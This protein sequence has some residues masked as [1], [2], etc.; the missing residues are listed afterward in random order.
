M[1]F[2]FWF[3]DCCFCLFEKKSRFVTNS[4]VVPCNKEA[5]IDGWY[6]FNMD[7]MRY[8][9][10]DSITQSETEYVLAVECWIF[11]TTMYTNWNGID[12]DFQKSV[13]AKLV[14]AVVPVVVCLS[15]MRFR[16]L[17]DFLI[18]DIW[19]RGWF[20]VEDWMMALEWG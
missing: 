19:K 20:E 14:I 5:K 18:F 12:D 2:E 6:F 1:T 17:K 4:A 11:T 10:L 3:A 16:C 7:S 15:M 9:M 13:I 8:A